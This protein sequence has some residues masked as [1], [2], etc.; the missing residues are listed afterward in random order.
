MSDETVSVVV[1]HE[2]TPSNTYTLRET[3][4]SD[5]LAE[6]GRVIG[7]RSMEDRIAAALRKL[8]EKSVGR[9]RPF[10]WCFEEHRGLHVGDLDIVVK[11][12]MTVEKNIVIALQGEGLLFEAPTDYTTRS[13]V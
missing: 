4:P 10:D 8:A 13:H 6:I 7:W 2:G 3:D 11:V 5:V 9:N 12:D 1:C